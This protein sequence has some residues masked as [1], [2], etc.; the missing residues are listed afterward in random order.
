MAVANVNGKLSKLTDAVIGVN[1][2][3][4]LY[5]DSLYEVI[6]I[7][8][9]I[10]LFWQDH[11]ARMYRSAEQLKMPISQSDIE[12]RREI[13]KPVFQSSRFSQKRKKVWI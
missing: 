2:R 4:F 10:P 5:G 1:D 6:F 7:R 11:F 9:G 12:I 8:N 13:L 3:G